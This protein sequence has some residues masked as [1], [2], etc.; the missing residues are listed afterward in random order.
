MNMNMTLLFLWFN[1]KPKAY[2]GFLDQQ[3]VFGEGGGL[4]FSVLD[5]ENEDQRR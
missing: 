1:W 2:W 3:Q 4:F 5:V